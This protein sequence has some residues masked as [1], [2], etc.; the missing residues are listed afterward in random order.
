MKPNRPGSASSKYTKI[1][2]DSDNTKRQVN[3]MQMSQ[4]SSSGSNS[5]IEENDPFK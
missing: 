4:T 3:L 5:F 2:Q 1:T